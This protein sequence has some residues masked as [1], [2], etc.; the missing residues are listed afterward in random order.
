[1]FLLQKQQMLFF[2]H[3]F[4]GFRCFTHTKHD[5]AALLLFLVFV[6]PLPSFLSSTLYAYVL[7]MFSFF[8]VFFPLHVFNA[9]TTA[10][11]T[12]TSC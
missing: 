12:G 6:M 7:F 8:Q 10:T 2:F 4:Y 5:E 9:P 3:T 1:M 11:T